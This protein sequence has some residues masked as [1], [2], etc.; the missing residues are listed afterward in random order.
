MRLCTQAQFEWRQVWVQMVQAIR[1]Y[2]PLKAQADSIRAAGNDDELAAALEYVGAS[3]AWQY[4][5]IADLF[6]PVCYLTGKCEFGAE[7]DRKCSIRNRVQA[8][9]EVGRPSSEW[10]QEL[11]EVED[12]PLV[13]GA[14][15]TSVLR[16]GKERPVFIGAIQPAEWLLDPK[17]AR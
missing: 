2:N 14:W 9:H 7:F 15:H 17:A 13:I 11:D 10:D 4:E 5:R 6:R 12:N 3:E 1:N 16:D 8:N